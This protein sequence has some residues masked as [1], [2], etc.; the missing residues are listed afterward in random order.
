MIK[1]FKLA[2]KTTGLPITRGVHPDTVNAIEFG[3]ERQF[4]IEGIQHIVGRAEQNAY[5]LLDAN[6]RQYPI[7]LCGRGIVHRRKALAL[8][9]DPQVKFLFSDD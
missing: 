3:E 6:N 7:K 5:Y 8:S 4:I 9:G 1:G 2:Q